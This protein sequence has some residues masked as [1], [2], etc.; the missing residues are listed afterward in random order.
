MACVCGERLQINALASI[1][2]L[3]WFVG[4]T[5][6]Q[7]VLPLAERVLVHGTRLEQDFTVIP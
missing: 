7:D 5:E 4:V 6:D 3:G 2:G 1:T